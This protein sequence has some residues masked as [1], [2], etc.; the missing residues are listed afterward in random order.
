MERDRDINRDDDDGD[1]AFDR[2]VNILG[3]ERIREVLEELRVRARME[4]RMEKAF[5]DHIREQER[6]NS[7]N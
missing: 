3:K 1:Y 6:M 7:N 4:A 2:I 5:F